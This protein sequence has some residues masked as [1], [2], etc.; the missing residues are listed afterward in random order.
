MPDRSERVEPVSDDIQN[1]LP[2]RRVSSE[3]NVFRLDT[4]FEKMLEPRYGFA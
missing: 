2:T 3:Q 4:Q 1:E